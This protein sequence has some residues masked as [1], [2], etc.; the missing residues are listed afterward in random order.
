MKMTLEKAFCDEGDEMD[1]VFSMGLQDDDQFLSFNV[2]LQN[3]RLQGFKSVRNILYLCLIA[4]GLVHLLL[5]G[6]GLH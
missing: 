4:R 6:R 3:L 1:F 5:C 2:M